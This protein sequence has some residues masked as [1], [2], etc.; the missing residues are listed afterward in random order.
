[1]THLSFPFY[2]KIKGVK[3]FLPAIT[4]VF[5][6]LICSDVFAQ[7]FDIGGPDSGPLA[8]ITN[9]L[10]EV[11]NFVNGPIALGFSFFCIA[12]MAMTWAFAPKFV[13]AMGTFVRITIAVI[14]ILNVGV[15]ITAYAGT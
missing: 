14:I 1:M 7:D 12:G 9:F 6:L 11:V 8:G 10:Q 2:K 4:S 5:L 13:A 3:C 15:W